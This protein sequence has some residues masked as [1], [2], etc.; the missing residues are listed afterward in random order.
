MGNDIRQPIPLTERQIE[1]LRET[2]QNGTTNF[3]AGYNLIYGWIKNNEAAKE[4]GTAFWFEQAR[5]INSGDSLSSRY[6]RRHTENGLDIAGVPDSER[7]D[8]QTLSDKIARNVTR[9]VLREGEVPALPVILSRD[10]SVALNDGNVKLGGWGGSFYYWDMPYKPDSHRGPGFPRDTDGSYRTIGDEIIS[11]G[12]VG[13]MVD[14][15]SR[16]MSQ[17]VMSRE[18][19]LSDIDD[20]GKT[21][22]NAGVPADI[23]GRIAARTVEILGRAGI[24]IID[25]KLEEMR[26]G[27]DRLRDR[28]FSENDRT[29]PDSRLA[30]IA[31]SD[32]STLSLVNSPS[33]P[34][35]GMHCAIQS[36]L[37][38]EDRLRG[39]DPHPG[40]AAIA[41]GLVGDARD[42]GL[43]T[44][45]FCKL[46]QDGRFAYI[47]NTTNPSAE[48]AK[49]AVG[50][51]GKA[52]QF[53]LQESSERVAQINQT[54][55]QQ[56]S[57]TQTIAQVTDQ[58]AVSPKTLSI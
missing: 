42:R 29:Q 35:Y 8:M 27:L 23:K 22:W 9:D 39:N 54:L 3:P 18:I 56:R 24:E 11:R 15:S 51:V 47:T 38:E 45:G 17:M 49:T 46:S 34:Q 21:A 44:I 5:G 36:T 6:I 30:S 25:D 55:E 16:T 4:D 40:G 58:S 1:Q 20:M 12:E 48:W 2:T 37:Q 50:D 52:A 19:K 53:T 43:D 26:D 32:A 14:A 13:L 7:V 41:A 31:N 57:Q 10:I 33:N 28:I